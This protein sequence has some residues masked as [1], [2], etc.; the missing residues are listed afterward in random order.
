MKQDAL[1]TAIMVFARAPVAGQVKTRLI[2]ALGEAGAAELHARFLGQTLNTVS[3]LENVAIQLFCQPNIHHPLFRQAADR[4]TLSLHPQQGY[5]LGERMANAFTGNLPHHQKV[6]VI[7]CDCPAFTPDDLRAAMDTLDDQD[8][9]IIPAHDGGYLL[10]G[11]R[12]FSPLIFTDIDW[13]TERVFEQTT[14]Q[15]D[16]AGLQWIALESK[17]DID[18]PEDLIH[19]PEHLLTGVTNEMAG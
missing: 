1:T 8:A 19:C 13:S 11:L 12:T 4:Y 2:P 17:Q 9:V 14:R 18:R 10:L 16:A 15:L 3:Q 6:L 7:G 5:D